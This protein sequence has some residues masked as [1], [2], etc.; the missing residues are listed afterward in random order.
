MKN[1]AGKFSIGSSLTSGEGR[2]ACRN[3]FINQ[4][5]KLEVPAQTHTN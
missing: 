5:Q 3:N 4:C 1:I 2:C